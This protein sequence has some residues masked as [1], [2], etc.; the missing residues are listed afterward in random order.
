MCGLSWPEKQREDQCDGHCSCPGGR[1]EP[2][3][4]RVKQS[5]ETFDA[6]LIN[7]LGEFKVQSLNFSVTCIARAIDT[8]TMGWTPRTGNGDLWQGSH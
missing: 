4:W 5:S 6:W 3:S 1:K 8:Y 2:S 7:V